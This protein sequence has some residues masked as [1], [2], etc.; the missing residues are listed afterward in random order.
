MNE[1]FQY[2]MAHYFVELN[3]NYNLQLES[4]VM[5][6]TL[7]WP[8]GVWNKYIRKRYRLIFESVEEIMVDIC[9]VLTMISARC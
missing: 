6:E 7:Q 4:L 2:I 1:L 5:P 3:L 8:T 9:I